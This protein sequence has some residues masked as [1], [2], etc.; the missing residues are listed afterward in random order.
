MENKIINYLILGFVFLMLG[1]ALIPTIATNTNDKTNLDVVASETHD[2]T[3]AFNVTTHQINESLAASNF[4][5]TNPPTGWE[6]AECTIT[7][8]T[9]KNDTTT[10]T[11]G[12]DYNF[13]SSTGLVQ[14]LN[15]TTTAG[16]GNTDVYAGYSYCGEGY[17]DS[18]WGRTILDLVPGFFALAMLGGAL[19]MFYNIFRE[20]GILTK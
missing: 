20:T 1:A 11:S 16:D 5:I 7:S 19:F 4:T 18:S 8:F 14:M 9:L 6:V 10:Y 13:F 3:T 17:L 2:I 12:T 15:T